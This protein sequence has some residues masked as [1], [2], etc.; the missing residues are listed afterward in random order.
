M[1]K[2]MT[3]DIEA[4]EIE[5]LCADNDTTEA[6]VIEALMEHIEEVKEEQGWK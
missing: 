4:R 2:L 5:K 3:Y 6:E 1:T